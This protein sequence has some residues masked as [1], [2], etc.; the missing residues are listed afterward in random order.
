MDLDSSDSGSLAQQFRE[1]LL[2]ALSYFRARMELAGLEGKEAFTQIGGVLLLAV[3]ALTL[4][5]SG[6]F[7]LCLALVF[8]IARL[9]ASEHA[10]VWIAAVFGLAHL[11]PAWGVFLGARGWVPPAEVPPPPWEIFKG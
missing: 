10:W 1:L 2:A 7:L 3:I 11:V 8:G 5:L 6:Y 9:L 4:T